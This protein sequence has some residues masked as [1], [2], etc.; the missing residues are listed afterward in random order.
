MQ[1]PVE[2]LSRQ[3]RDV[4]G[5][6]A[7]GIRDH[8]LL[9]GRGSRAGPTWTG[10]ARPAR[11]GSSPTPAS[12]ATGEWP[13]CAPRS[14]PAAAVQR[15]HLREHRAQPA[16]TCSTRCG[17][18]RNCAPPACSI[19]ATD[20]P[21]D[22]HAPEAATIL[23][24]RVKMGDS[25]VLPVQPQDPD[26]GRPQAIRHQRAQHRAM[27]LRLR[28]GPHPPPQPDESQHGSHPRPPHPRPRAR[29]VGHPDVP[30]AGLGEA[31]ASPGI[32]R[33]LTRGQ[34]PPPG[35]ASRGAPAPSARSWPTPSTPAGS[36][37][38]RT[39]NT[40]PPAPGQRRIA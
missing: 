24:R 6:A 37:L 27:P 35:T 31:V 23:V 19:F 29:P 1:D 40:G 18:K 11:G 14:R 2:S 32:A 30:M 28:R 5:A 21:I 16:A 38:G 15:G 36:S 22:V 8:P 33:R 10:A 9:L 39:R 13:S 20:E 25:R 17:W 4:T 7:R 3:L 26:V 34:P 12:P